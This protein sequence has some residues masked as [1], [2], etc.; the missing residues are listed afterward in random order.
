MV[1]SVDSLQSVTTP[2]CS[3]MAGVPSYC[4]RSHVDNDV[5]EVIYQSLQV[6]HTVPSTQLKT[7]KQMRR[8]DG[9]PENQK[10]HGRVETAPLESR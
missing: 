3:R 7:T 2:A 6:F 10:K 5:P 9:M 8:Q 4:R 1:P